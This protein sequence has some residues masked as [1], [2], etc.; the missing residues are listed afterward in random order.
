LDGFNTTGIRRGEE[1]VSI[2]LSSMPEVIGFGIAPWRNELEKVGELCTTG[3]ESS[4]SRAYDMACS[5]PKASASR[6]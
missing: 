1:L 6:N 2:L 4:V 3:Q 5:C